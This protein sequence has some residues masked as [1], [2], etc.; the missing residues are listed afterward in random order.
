MSVLFRASLGFLI[1]F[2]VME[3][4]VL[5]AYFATPALRS[6]RSDLA[7]A[8]HQ[9]ATRFDE[10][11]AAPLDIAIAGAAHL[12]RATAQIREPKV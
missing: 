12:L 11:P 1:A 3:P 2:A 10:H 5:A 8:E 9:E 4:Q 7:N 6:V